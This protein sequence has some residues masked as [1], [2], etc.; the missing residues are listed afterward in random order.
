MYKI[1]TP[2]FDKYPILCQ[3]KPIKFNAIKNSYSFSNKKDILLNNSVLPQQPTIE[4]QSKKSREFK[5]SNVMKANKINFD[6]VNIRV[7]KGNRNIS[8]LPFGPLY[9]NLMDKSGNENNLFL[10]FANY[11]NIRRINAINLK[12]QK[13]L[14]YPVVKSKSIFL[15][16]FNDKI[17]N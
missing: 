2:K 16:K 11:S 6:N 14:N 10:N 9:N 1:L 8:M 15:K 4:I 12:N 13:L 5:I 17:E 7:N 3:L